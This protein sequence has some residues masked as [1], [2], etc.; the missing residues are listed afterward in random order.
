MKAISSTDYSKSA[1][2]EITKSVKNITLSNL[3]QEI[4]HY[5]SYWKWKKKN[6]IP[7]NIMFQ[8]YLIRTLQRH[9]NLQNF[10]DPLHVYIIAKPISAPTANNLKIKKNHVFKNPLKNKMQWI[11]FLLKLKLQFQKHQQSVQNW[12]SNTIKLK[13]IS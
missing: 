10:I 9:Q 3:V 6:N 4:S 13:R 7:Y 5:W 2:K 1:H 11:W 12:L 8:K